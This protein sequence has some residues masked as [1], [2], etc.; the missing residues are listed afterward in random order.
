M[1]EQNYPINQWAKDDR[2]REKLRSKGPHLLSDSELI[3]ILINK[4]TRNRNAVDL[5]KDLLKLGKNHL[6]ELGKL[7]IR[8]LMKVPGIGEAKA[9]TISAALEIGRRRET[10]SILGKV[11]IKSSKEIA[12]YIKS[13]LRDLQN[14]V[15]GVVF[16][17]RANKVEHYEIISVGG[18]TGTVADP[19]VIFKKALAEDAVSLILFHNHP[20]GNLQPSTADKDLT[21]KIAQAAKL[22]DIRILDHLIV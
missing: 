3:A 10:S 7:S 11:I 22:F 20:S 18:I 12:N 16:L 19:R 2:P 13:I 8:E 14:E 5:A 17:N 1:Q 4:G 15:F 21:V 6:A 9:I